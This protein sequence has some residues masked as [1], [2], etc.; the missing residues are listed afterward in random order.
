MTTPNV[1]VRFEFSV[2]LPGT[3]EQ[4]WQA[5]A[6]GPG[7]TAWSMPT[8]LEGRP[9]GEYVAHMGETSARGI[10]A[11]WEPPFRFVLEEPEWA[12]LAG[13]EGADV[14]PLVTEFLV[15]SE[16]GGSCVLRVVS[17]AFGTGADWEREFMDEAAKY[18]QPMF[19][20]LRIFLAA[21]PGQRA[22]VVESGTEL[23]SDPAEVVTAMCERFGA[24]AAGD[25]IDVHGVAGRVEKVTEL[26]VLVR[27]T[28]PECGF[29]NL[30]SYPNGEQTA[31]ALARE[32]LFG[33]RAAELA[34]IHEAAWK[35]WFA[36]LP[37]AA[38]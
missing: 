25:A 37:A 15:E 11:A 20:N 14:T 18:W 12:A 2:E 1:P 27:Y 23:S 26:G 4:V 10:V 7:L 30:I 17:S 16:S 24:T 36:E 35:E 38:S 8:D 32:Y 34:A 5:I 28:A 9:G 13:H 6:T 22:T 3:P 19:D 31:Y 21:F 29:L 33:D